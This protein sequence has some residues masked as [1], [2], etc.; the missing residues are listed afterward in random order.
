M[1]I[2]K[3][4]DGS[5]VPWDVDKIVEA[6]N[7]SSDRVSEDHRITAEQLE[8]IT[9]EVE[10]KFCQ[11]EQ[12][13]TYDIHEAVM[14]S[15]WKVNRAVY[16]E[17]RLYRDYKKKFARS[18][19]SVNEFSNKIVYS[20]DKENANKDSTLNST[21]QALISEGIMR[22]LMTNF[23]LRQEW[24]EAHDSGWIHIHDL[25]NKF[26][27]GFNCC[28]FDMGN[29]LKDGFELNGSK[30][31]EP[32]SAQT[33]WAVIGDVTL[34]ASAQQFGGFS[35]PNIESIV[36]PYAEK[37]Y[38]S[39][40]DYFID[41]GID[42]DKAKELAEELTIR[43]IEQGY[44]GFETKLNTVSNS[45]GQIPFVS[46]SFGLDT[47]KWGRIISK[48]MIETRTKGM[49][50]DRI[51]A[52][53]PKQILFVR[54]EVN[55]N[56][57]SPNHDI[58]LQAI[59]CSRTRLYP[60]YLSLDSPETNNL[61]EVYERCGQAV[62]PMGCRAYLSPYTY[63]GNEIY[64]GRFN[65]GAVSLNLPKIAIES[66]GDFGKFYELI[67]K[68][69]DM[70]FDI[71]EDYYDRLS[72]VKAS[73]NPLFFMEGGSFKKLAAEDTIEEL[74]EGATASLGYVGLSE[75]M[76]AMTGEGL[77]ENKD[78]AIDVV[79]HLKRQVGDACSV[80]DR[81]YALYSTPA[82]NIIY[83]FNQ[84]NKQQYGIID[85][86][87]SRDYMTNSFHV[88]VFEDISVL[89]K[90]AFEAPFHE[91]ATGGRIS[92]NEFP[93]G[94]SSEVLKQAID[95][96]MSL[97]LYYGVNVISA[98]CSDC[99]HVGD[100]DVCD[101]CGSDNVTSVSRV[102]GYLSF[103]KIKGYSRYNLGKQAEVRDRVKH[104]KGD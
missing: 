32:K 16:K 4:K 92:Y 40:Y 9:S 43:E 82:E 13:S 77:T 49:G 39:H 101:R 17:Y 53:F 103:G 42:T 23:E 20:G 104:Y 12:V 57:D 59:E 24:I 87:T 46:I 61:A 84:L 91:I 75:A 5:S 96:A 98:S 15:L 37:S 63:E 90:M 62:T 31:F 7:L 69:S 26:L 28:I 89:D 11:K 33:A 27:G 6:V 93:Y 21:K 85:N 25:A 97:G 66:G 34:S 67:E 56:E 44:Q 47:S 80:Y 78:V 71:H 88:P 45:L 1:V 30:Y 52:I 64:A 94:V 68:Y 35:I 18:L 58:Y 3:K 51:T 95:Y 38:N 72:K 19:M 73:S 60:D 10:S 65:I 86:V 79:K 76:V 36:A 8:S 50:K 83:R 99:G 81:K 102:C 48:T 100:F 22:E 74:L 29:L 14:T 54:S 41:K 55:K 2:V 70:A